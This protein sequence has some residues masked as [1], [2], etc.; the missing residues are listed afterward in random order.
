MLNNLFD[1][2]EQVRLLTHRGA[3]GASA[4]H[5]AIRRG[6]LEFATYL[7]RTTEAEGAEHARAMLTQ[8]DDCGETCLHSIACV[9]PVASEGAS[10]AAAAEAESELL[11]AFLETLLQMG[12]DAALVTTAKT[13]R[14]G[15]AAAAEGA[16]A[17]RV[18]SEVKGQSALHYCAARGAQT[19]W[20][21][22]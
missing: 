16:G 21:G 11:T 22:A 15:G 10:I 4:L 3:G 5:L 8:R 9:D 14:S 6:Q 18:G 19:H 1:H 7:L 2:I 13:A 12:A 17:P 20:A